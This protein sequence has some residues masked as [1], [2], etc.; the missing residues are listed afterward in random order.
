M[1]FFFGSPWGLI[2]G[3]VKTSKQQG[4]EP[5]GMLTLFSFSSCFARIHCLATVN[6]VGFCCHG[7]PPSALPLF[8]HVAACMHAGR[9]Y[10]FE[11]HNVGCVLLSHPCV[12]FFFVFLCLSRCV[13][14]VWSESGSAHPGSSPHVVALQ[15]I[16]APCGIASLQRNSNH[17][18]FAIRRAAPGCHN[19]RSKRRDSGDCLS[20]ICSCSSL[21]HN[22]AVC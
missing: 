3:I 7:A 16:F 10:R 5:L 11:R 15:I 18:I 13:T 1:S 17:G 4:G 6:S 8:A 2:V 20:L 12:F 14:Q 21:L 22:S 19:K 9:N